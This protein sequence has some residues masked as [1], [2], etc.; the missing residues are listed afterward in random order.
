MSVVPLPFRPR[1]PNACSDGIFCRAFF[2][3]AAQHRIKAAVD[4][5]LILAPA[6]LLVRDGTMQ[7]RDIPHSCLDQGQQFAS[8]CDLQDAAG[9]VLL[10][11]QHLVVCLLPDVRRRPSDNVGLR[12]LQGRRRFVRS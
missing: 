6:A 2:L 1:N 4:V 11:A 7:H 9:F 3:G 5:R 10:D 12:A 8:Q